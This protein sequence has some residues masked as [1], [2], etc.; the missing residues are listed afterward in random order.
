MTRQ[1]SAPLVHINL[2]AENQR[3]QG[4]ADM[5]T[6][7]GWLDLNPPYQRASVW[8]ED[9]RIALVR[10]WLTGV[11]VPAVIL[12]DRTSRAFARTHGDPGDKFLV[13]VDG[14]QRIETAIAWFTGALAVPASWFEPE[15]ITDGAGQDTADG[16]YVTFTDL[17]PAGQRLMSN[18]AALPSVRAQVGS[19]A[20][21][22]DLYLLVNG[23]GTPQT[24]DDLTNAAR[25]ASEM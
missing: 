6:D 7:M 17:T 23:G 1:T 9:Q 22:A 24:E 2:S 8:T 16:R 15:R 18:R 4:L 25:H 19:I 21:E 20:E 11:P 5:V 3:A 14:K 13:C 10:S 12:N